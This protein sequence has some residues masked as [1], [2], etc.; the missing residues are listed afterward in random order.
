MFA[1]HINSWSDWGIKDKT[2]HS[3][4]ESVFIS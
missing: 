3:T 1:N 4:V 2:N